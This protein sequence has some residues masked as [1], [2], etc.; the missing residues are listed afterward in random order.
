MIELKP[1]LSF[2]DASAIGLGAIIGGGIFVV[3][4]V[5]AGVAGPAL[6][7][8]ILIAGFVSL[9]TARSFVALTS[10]KTAE[11]SIYEFARVLLS[12]FAGFLAGWMW[13]IANIFTGAAVSLGFAHYFAALF[14]ALDARL[15]VVAVALAFTGLNYI[16]IKHSATINNALVALKIG[17]LLVFIG[18]GAVHLQP[19][20]FRP[21]VPSTAGV[22]QGAFFIFFAFSGFGRVAV[23]AEQVRD[24]K[25]NVPRSIMAALGISALLYI[26]VG[27]V[28]VGL[29]P[30]D[31]LAKSPSP[32]AAAIGTIGHPVFLLIIAFGGMVATASVLLT[33]ILGVSHMG[34]AM[35]RQGDLPRFISRLHPRFATPGVAILAVGAAIIVISLFLNL[36]H[37]VSISTFAALFNYA[38]ANASAFRLGVGDG[39]R[40]VTAVLGFVTCVSLAAFIQRTALTFGIITVVLGV[41]IYILKKK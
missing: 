27:T 11:G 22:F 1:E 26:I 10:W 4:G 18:A 13:I 28:A 32:L 25:K 23:L 17:V 35:A 37:V 2:W 20:H 3:T 8:S 14:P 33:S 12:P 15:A 7:I 6:V 34:Y 38:L 39:R 40:K 36:T 30:A 24:A 16:G 31:T 5:V 21:F 41:I 29:A 9:L 19:G